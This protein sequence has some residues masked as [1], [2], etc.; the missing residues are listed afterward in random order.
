MVR[1]RDTDALRDQLQNVSFNRASF[2][3]WPVPHGVLH[4]LTRHLRFRSTVEVNTSSRAQIS[5]PVADTQEEPQQAS[6]QV[7]QEVEDE[8]A[9]EPAAPRRRI[10]GLQSPDSSAPASTR[11]MGT[12]RTRAASPEKGSSEPTRTATVTT[13]RTRRGAKAEE[14]DGMVTPAGQRVDSSSFLQKVTDIEV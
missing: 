12:R 3:Y 2:F 8:V 13:R 11:T 4:L 5:E 6:P 1:S 7:K 14:D 10:R 9:V